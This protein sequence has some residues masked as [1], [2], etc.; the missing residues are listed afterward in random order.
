MFDGDHHSSWD[1]IYKMT[2]RG[3]YVFDV[4]RGV[5]KRIDNENTQ[6]YG[7]NGKGTG[8]VTLVSVEQLEPDRVKAFE[9]ESSI[10]RGESE[11]S[12]PTHQCEQG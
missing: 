10:L 8:D 7:F 1:R 9:R 2:A 11:V 6:G 3:H 12:R 5:V 4:R